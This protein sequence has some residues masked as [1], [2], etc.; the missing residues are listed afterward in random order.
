MRRRTG[1]QR[2]QAMLEA[3]LLAALVTLAAGLAFGSLAGSLDT[4][5]RA[6]RAFYTL[7]IP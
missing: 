3:A 1:G 6:H 5:R 4:R 7:P 2:G